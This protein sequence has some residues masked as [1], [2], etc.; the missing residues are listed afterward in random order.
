MSDYHELKRAL[1]STSRGMINRR[2][3]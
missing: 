3:L 1:R 2:C